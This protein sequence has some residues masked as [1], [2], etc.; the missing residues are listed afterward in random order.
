[1]DAIPD[2]SIYVAPSSC[3]ITGVAR[4][5]QSWRHLNVNGSDSIVS[6]PI[7]VELSKSQF[8]SKLKAAIVFGKSITFFGFSDC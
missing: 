1:M 8:A 7:N 3:I 4:Y 5:D 2:T 6:S